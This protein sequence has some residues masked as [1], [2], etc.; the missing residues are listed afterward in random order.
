MLLAMLLVL[1]ASGRAPADDFGNRGDIANLPGPLKNRLVELNGR[2]HSFSPLTVFSEAPDPSLLFGYYPRYD[3][4]IVFIFTT[5]HSGIND[6]AVPTAGALTAV[7][8]DRRRAPRGRAEPDLPKIRDRGAFSRHIHRRVAFVI[9]ANR[10]GE[11][12]MIA[13]QGAAVCKKLR[14]TARACFGGLTRADA[15]AI[16][17]RDRRPPQRPAG[18]STDGN[19]AALPSAETS[20]R[21]AVQPRPDPAQHGAWTLCSR[22]TRTLL[23]VQPVHELGVPELRA[24]QHRRRLTARPS[25]R[26]IS[27]S[28]A[29]DRRASQ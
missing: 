12:W 25:R 23:G 8:D 29:P 11:G 17:P 2:P 27:L 6:N 21:Q 24:R 5:R 3:R 18:F 15:D 1:G 4:P 13:T 7:A 16:A 26:G 19:G 10:A 22:P 14:A 9:N 20:S 28:P